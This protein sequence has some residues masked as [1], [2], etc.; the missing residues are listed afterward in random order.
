MARFLKVLAIMLLILGIVGFGGY[1]YLIWGMDEVLNS[2]I[3]NVD[4]QVLPDG[5]YKGSYKN[6]RWS[7]SVE[8][9]ISDGRIEGIKVTDDVAITLEEPRTQLI[10]RVIKSQAVDV[11]AVSGA[12]ATSKAYLLAIEAALS[13]AGF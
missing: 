12:T 13:S 8:V 3:G 1:S 4:I 10:D 2:Q 6:S 5:T 7:N 9:S 11:D